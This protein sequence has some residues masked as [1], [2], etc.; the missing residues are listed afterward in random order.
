MDAN[1]DISISTVE[2][3]LHDLVAEGYLVMV[4][5]G[6]GAGYERADRL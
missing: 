1:P 4:G 6:R 2:N 3:A 5:T